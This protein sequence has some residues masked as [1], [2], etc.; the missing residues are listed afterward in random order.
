MAQSALQTTGLPAGQSKVS[1]QEDI[2][3]YV[4]FRNRISS[5]DHK[6]LDDIAQ[7]PD[8]SGPALVLKHLDRLR[9]KILRKES[10]FIADLSDEMID[11]QWDIIL[12][13]VQEGTWSTITLS[14]W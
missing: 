10:C 3:L 5:Q 9:R 4:S 7:L 8:V 13:L 12:A 2:V 6:P 1:A 14:L 11:Q